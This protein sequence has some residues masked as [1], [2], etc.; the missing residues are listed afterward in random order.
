MLERTVTVHADLVLIIIFFYILQINK[1]A[2]G[3]K[4]LST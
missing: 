1:M 2:F 4:K 3:N